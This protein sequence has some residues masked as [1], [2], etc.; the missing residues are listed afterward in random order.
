MKKGLLLVAAI[1]ALGWYFWAQHETTFRYR[2]T[3]N[4][5]SDG[6][7]Y[8]GSGV[9]QE[10]VI[11]NTIR[12]NGFAWDAKLTGDAVV[13]EV[14]GRSPIFA[15]LST[16][17]NV[18]WADSIAF[19]MFRNELPDPQQPAAKRENISAMVRL[20]KKAEIPVERYPMLVA[21]RDVNDLETVYE[22][23]PHDLSEALGIGSYVSGMTIEMTRDPVTEG[24]LEKSLRCASKIRS[25]LDGAVYQTP[26]SSL[27][28]ALSQV[29]F[30]KRGI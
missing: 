11:V 25:T 12:L 17:K 28:N 24:M 21:F 8:S 7:A 22:L 14:P 13:V 10:Q 3:V 9:I 30:I 18:D 4:V 19:A 6:Q 29:D 15:L 1:A 23:N 20:R 27:S 16:K 26:G 5:V 2:L